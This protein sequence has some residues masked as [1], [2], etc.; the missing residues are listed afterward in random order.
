M[1]RFAKVERATS[2][3]DIRLE[4]ELDGTGRTDVTTGCRSSITC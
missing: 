3:T 1:G 4:L 2:E